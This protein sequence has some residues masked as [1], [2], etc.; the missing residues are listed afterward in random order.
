[1]YSRQLKSCSVLLHHGH[2]L[3]QQPVVQQSICKSSTPKSVH[4]LGSTQCSGASQCSSRSA[5][6]QKAVL[7]RTSETFRTFRT[8]A[9]DVV[10]ST[11]SRKKGRWWKATAGLLLGT[12]AVY[13]FSQDEQERR[14][15]RVFVGGVRRFLRSLIIGLNISLDYKWSLWNMDDESDEYKVAIKGCHRRAADRILSGCLKNGGLYIKLG[16]GFVSLNHILP[17]EYVEVLTVL[18]DRAL[19]SKPHEVEQLFLEDFGKKPSEMFAEFDP[20]PIAAASLAQVHIAK[21]HDGREVAVKV[22]YIDLRDRFSGDINTCEFLL[23]VIGWIHPKFGFAWVLQDLKETLRQELDFEQEARNGEKCRSDL[24]HLKYVYVP[25]IFWD[26]TTKRV[27][28]TEF[29]HGCKISNQKAI[30]DMGLSIKDVDY[31][32]IQCFSDQIF[33][34]GFVH[35][36]P[37]PGNVFVRRGEKGTAQLVLLDHGLYDSLKPHERKALCQLYKAIIMLQED[38][39]Q[40]FSTALGVEDYAVFCEILVQRPIQR[41]TL[42]LPSKMTDEDLA[43][44]RTMAQEH[45]DKIMAVLKDMPRP[46]ILVIRNLN[47][48][49]AITREHGHTVDRYGI[50]ARSAI[51]GVYRDVTTKGILART[52]GFLDRCMFDYHVWRENFIFSVVSMAV[53]TYLRILHWMG[54]A[55]DLAQFD[56]VLKTAEKKFEQV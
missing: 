53:R 32:L 16:Q 25:E 43:H 48:I 50:M 37:H 26:T 20:E 54:R 13:Y 7:L 41:Q 24:K 18:Q 17:R 1:M 21:R 38:K 46:L 11:S 44:M 8:K 51:T 3:P 6:L 14:K 27:L 4:R 45:F 19:T 22:Q 23:R 56:H 55:P 30:E 35:A 34:S 40:E 12:G 5:L 49:R 9:K 52:R 29:I 2:R 39:M 10:D 42:H 15:M 33:L 47:T 28:V 36:D 31:K